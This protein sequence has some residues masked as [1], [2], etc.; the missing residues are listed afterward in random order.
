MVES[1]LPLMAKF[2]KEVFTIRELHFRKSSLSLPWS[3]LPLHYSDCP[4]K[5]KLSWDSPKLFC[6]C[7]MILS[8]LLLPVSKS[9]IVF[10]HI[11][12]NQINSQS[13]S[14]KARTEK[15][16]K[17]KFVRINFWF[18]LLIIIRSS[19]IYIWCLRMRFLV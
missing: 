7:F 18:L 17:E 12:L 4:N 16:V 8:C 10:F 2:K 15:R 14:L 19:C 13:F 1:V 11:N 6:H 9:K 3:H 5:T